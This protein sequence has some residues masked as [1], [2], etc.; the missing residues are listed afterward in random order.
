MWFDK[1]HLILPENDDECEKRKKFLNWYWN[2]F[3]PAA[4]GATSFPEEHRHYK[5]PSMPLKIKDQPDLKGGAVTKECEAFAKLVARNCYK[6]WGFIIP[7]KLEDS[8]W[9]LPKWDKDDEKTHKYHE[10]LWSDGRNG[11]KKGQGW[12]AEAYEE[13]NKEV[14]KVKLFRAADKKDGWKTLKSALAL[15]K[16]MNG[17]DLAA[18]APNKK[19]KRK[20]KADEPK[21]VYQKMADLSDDDFDDDELGDISALAV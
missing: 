13:M 8:D 11:Q 21:V 3:L 14:E 4:A 1:P 6:K 18:T 9:E 16:T 2:H 10:T 5:L 7:E 20:G 15:V 17:I 12:S 19:R